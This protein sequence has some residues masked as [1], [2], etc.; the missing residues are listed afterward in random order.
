MEAWSFSKTNLF[1]HAINL[2][3]CCLLVSVTKTAIKAG[4]ERHQH[5][6]YD[7][8]RTVP[9]ITFSTI[10]TRYSKPKALVVSLSKCNFP[11]K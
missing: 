7:M 11:G 1:H 5:D 10:I 8:Q 4:I 9:D 3:M 2:L 6:S